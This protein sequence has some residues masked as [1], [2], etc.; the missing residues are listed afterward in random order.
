MA[1]QVAFTHPR[2]GATYPQAY[3]Q[4]TPLFNQEAK[5]Y[6]VRLAIYADV[7]AATANKEPILRRDVKL[8]HQQ[9]V[10]QFAATI[11]DR[12]DTLLIAQQFPG[13]VKVPEV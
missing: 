10:N 6:L 1:L 7:A 5:T 13:G 9:Y 8:T 12:I 2:T 3:L 11:L 4:A